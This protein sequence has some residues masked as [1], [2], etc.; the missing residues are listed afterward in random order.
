MLSNC[1]HVLHCFV[2]LTSMGKDKAALV[3]CKYGTTSSSSQWSIMSLSHWD[4]WIIKRM[5]TKSQ[6]CQHC[7]VTDG[8]SEGRYLAKA[9]TF[10]LLLLLHATGLFAC[11]QVLRETQARMQQ[12]PPPPG[13]S[14]PQKDSGLGATG[15]ATRKEFEVCYYPAHLSV[16][17]TTKQWSCEMLAVN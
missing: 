9:R 3:S 10:C 5:H 13:S 1:A 4:L 16:L 15:N 12:A 6:N 7:H 17:L 11:V 2:L 14:S 8:V